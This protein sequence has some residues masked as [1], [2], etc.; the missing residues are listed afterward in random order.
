MTQS[1]VS[2]LNSNGQVLEVDDISCD[3]LAIFHTKDLE[4]ILSVSFQVM[5]AKVFLQLLREQRVILEPFRDFLGIDDVGLEVVEGSP[6]QVREDVVD[7]REVFGEGLG[8][9]TEIE[10]AE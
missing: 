7:L 1:S 5:R 8:A 2:P 10:L 4:L 3:A 9:V 6:F